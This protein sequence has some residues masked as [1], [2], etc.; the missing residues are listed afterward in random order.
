MNSCC[1]AWF[2]QEED[3]SVRVQERCS[4]LFQLFLSLAIVEFAEI[5]P[6]STMHHYSDFLV[7]K[8]RSQ[9]PIGNSPLCFLIGG[10]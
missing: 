10:F 3:K 5:E 6:R 1:T 9:A 8:L 7:E 2:R 4:D